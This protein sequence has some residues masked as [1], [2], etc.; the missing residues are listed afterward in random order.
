MGFDLYG[1]HPSGVDIQEPKETDSQEEWHRYFNIRN[2]IDG[3]YFRANVWTWR[4]IWSFVVQHCNDIL[5]NNDLERGEY[6]DGHTI[7]SDKSK[8]MSIRI[9]EMLDDGSV[10]KHKKEFDESKKSLPDEI[11]KLCEGTGTRKGWEGWQAEYEWLKT[12]ETLEPIKENTDEDSVIKSLQS[13]KPIQVGYKWANTCNGCNSCHGTGKTKPFLSSYH[14]EKEL[15]EE[16]QFFLENCGGFT[17][18]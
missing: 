17:I 8:A 2:T 1:V 15:V 3:G 4:P 13:G 10:D 11:C 18:C 9:K 5:N 16:F 14:F 12:H 6:N 7:T